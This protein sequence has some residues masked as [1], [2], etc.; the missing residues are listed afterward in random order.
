MLLLIP[1]AQNAPSGDVAL[2]AQY[3]VLGVAVVAL[4]A[5]ARQAYNREKDRADRA[6][7]KLELLLE[8][9]QREYTPTVVRANDLMTNQVVPLLAELKELP[10]VIEDMKQELRRRNRSE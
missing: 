3:G 2:F 10:K 5:F 6:E 9:V 7:A 1:F 8:N 4:A